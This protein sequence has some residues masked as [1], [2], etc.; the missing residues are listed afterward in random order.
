[1]ID[2]TTL[3]SKEMEKKYNDYSNYTFL[4]YQNLETK[5]FGY[6]GHETML[7]TSKGSMNI[8]QMLPKHEDDYQDISN[9][10][11]SPMEISKYTFFFMRNSL[12]NGTII[13]DSQTFY[14]PEIFIVSHTCV[15]H[16]NSFLNRLLFRQPASIDKMTVRLILYKLSSPMEGLLYYNDL[17]EYIKQF[18]VSFC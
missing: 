9:F 14:M 2:M 18:L 15:N 5:E 6:F 11:I 8:S 10:P 17:Q 3:M 1:M 12:Q 16:S 13:I 7:T 4:I